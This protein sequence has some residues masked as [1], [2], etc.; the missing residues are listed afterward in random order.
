MPRKRFVMERFWE[1]VNITTANDCWEW[2]GYRDAKGYGRFLVSDGNDDRSH[3]VAARIALGLT[4]LVPL[5]LGKLV[6][7]HCDNPGCCNPAHLYI[8]TAADN[9]RD[10]VLRGHSRNGALI[11][12]GEN[13]Y[14]AILN[15]QQVREIRALYRPN[16]MGYRKLANRYGVS[17]DVIRSVVKRRSWKWLIQ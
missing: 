12:R 1:K 5:P 11:N 4:E 8:G 14:A 9:N 10:K 13:H 6:C 7:H 16:K 17:W 2:L 15:E 3:R